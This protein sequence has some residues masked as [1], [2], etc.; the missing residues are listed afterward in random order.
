MKRQAG[1]GKD[2]VGVGKILVVTAL[3][4]VLSATVLFAAAGTWRRPW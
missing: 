4:L 1:S 3:T 2:G